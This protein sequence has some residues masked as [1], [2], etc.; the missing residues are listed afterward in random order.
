MNASPN[1][2]RAIAAFTILASALSATLAGCS[3]KTSTV[4]AAQTPPAA[5]DTNPASPAEYDPCDIRRH[6]RPGPRTS[7][8][9][10]TPAGPSPRHPAWRCV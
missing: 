3:N 5:A 2:W 9:P 4:P 7:A 8:C 6:S 1:R 10:A